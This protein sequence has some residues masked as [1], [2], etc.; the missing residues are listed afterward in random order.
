MLS[1]AKAMNERKTTAF[2]VA[3]G[4]YLVC[5]TSDEPVY[6]KRINEKVT[7]YYS[8]ETDALVG[9]KV[10]AVVGTNGERKIRK[11]DKWYTGSRRNSRPVRA[12][13]HRGGYCG[14]DGSGR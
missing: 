10:S 5:I 9:V 6:A 11:I 4:D 7:G 14:D 1:R 2:Y 13:D 12:D 3:A 8:D